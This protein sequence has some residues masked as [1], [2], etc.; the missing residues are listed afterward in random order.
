[1]TYRL[2][3]RETIGQ[4]GQEEVEGNKEDVEF[5]ALLSKEN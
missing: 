4:D 1:M 2:A 3:N 5:T